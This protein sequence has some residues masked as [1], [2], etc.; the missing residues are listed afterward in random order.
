[1]VVVLVTVTVSWPAAVVRLPGRSCA[2]GTV[3]LRITALCWDW[4]G[5]Q[6]ED[7]QDQEQN[8]SQFQALHLRGK[9]LY[10]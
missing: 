8:A 9:P 3:A 4:W 1:M 7:H 2:A 6:G 5:H 10:K